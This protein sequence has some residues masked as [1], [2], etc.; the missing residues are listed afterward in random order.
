MISPLLVMCNAGA[1]RIL[2]HLVSP[3]GDVGRTVAWKLAAGLVSIAPNSTVILD[4]S[5]GDGVCPPGCTKGEC[6][7]IA[8][9]QVVGGPSVTGGVDVISV[10]VP[11]FTAPVLSLN[12][13]VQ[14]P[15]KVVASAT[16]LSNDSVVFVTLQNP[17]GF[18]ESC[19]FA[20]PAGVRVGDLQNETGGGDDAS[21]EFAVEAYPIGD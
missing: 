1:A 2:T 19:T 6:G 14:G 5:V 9:A 21:D 7:G 20:L 17:M 3:Q 11:G 15:P 13:A 10:T 18:P 4:D 12:V 8:S 16:A